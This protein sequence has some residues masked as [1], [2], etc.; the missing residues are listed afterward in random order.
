MEFV[1]KSLLLLRTFKLTVV[2]TIQCG[3]VYC[4]FFDDPLQQNMLARG[5]GHFN[6]YGTLCGS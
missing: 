6:G 5:I 3:W 2:A 4:R 1:A